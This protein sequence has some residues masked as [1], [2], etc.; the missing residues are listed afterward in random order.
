MYDYGGKMINKL[1]IFLA[2]LVIGIVFISGCTRSNEEATSIEITSIDVASVD[3]MLSR[4]DNKTILMIVSKIRNNMN[5]NTASLTAKISII[6]SMTNSSIAETDSD[7]SYIQNKS[8]LNSFVTMTVPVPGKYIVDTQ[9]FENGKILSR[10]STIVTVPIIAAKTAPIENMTPLPT[11]HPSAIVSS[12]PTILVEDTEFKFSNKCEIRKIL[13][14]S[15]G[16][17]LACIKAG[18]EKINVTF[19]GTSVS[20]IYFGS[21]NGGI[22][23][24]QIDE[25]GY[26]EIDM[27]VIEETE[28]WKLE[29]TLRIKK[30]IAGNLQNTS[31]RLTFEIANKS[32]PQS[33]IVNITRKGNP[34][35][36]GDIY[37]D[38]IEIT[39]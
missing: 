36:A 23:K 5:V 39:T 32:N 22:V 31:H 25:K 35:E 18:G 16:S 6:D 38:A 34:N 7:I 26:P 12:K 17:L 9:I 1:R 3:D 8:T 27:L 4:Q 19:T 37:I 15:N 2:L 10:N 14:A 13:R 28:P 29:N 11:V 24:V 30:Q 33:G 20:V 21:P